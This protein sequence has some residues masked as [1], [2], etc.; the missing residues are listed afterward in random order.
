[1]YSSEALRQ[2]FY[3]IIQTDEALFVQRLAFSTK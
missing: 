2:A 1:M 3:K